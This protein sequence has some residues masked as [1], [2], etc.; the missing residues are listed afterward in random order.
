MAPTEPV[1]SVVIPCYNYGRYLPGCV[2]SVVGQKGVLARVLIIDDTSTDDSAEV[3]RALAAQ[4]PEVTFRH[5]ETNK[6]HIATYNEGLLE[7]ADGD[8]VTLLSADDMLTPGALGRAVAIMEAH[9]RVGMVYGRQLDM[10][11][12]EAL[13]TLSGKERRPIVMEGGRWLTRRCREAVNVV[14]TPGTVLRT[15]VQKQVGGYDPALPHA[16]DFEMWLRV[17][18]VSDIGYVR[19]VPQGLYRIH[20]ASM[21]QEVYRHRLADVRQRKMVFDAVFDTYAAEA[22]KAGIDRDDAYRTLASEPLWLAARAYE[23]GRTGEVPIDECVE[24]AREIFPGYAS[25]GAYRA[26]QRRRRLGPDVCRRTQLFIASAALRRARNRLW[27]WRWK[28]YGG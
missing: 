3:G 14:P 15:S 28:R 25:L 5:H 18:A 17:A 24:T 22:T 16:G 8:Y 23:T 13:P 2:D 20:R 27:W 21:S 26:L 7:W 12:D 19:G 9:P 1:V 6:G 10:V 11:D 4:H